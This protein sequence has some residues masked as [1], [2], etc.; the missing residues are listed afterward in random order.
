MMDW[1]RGALVAGM[2]LAG[3]ARADTLHMTVAASPTPLP[4]WLPLYVAA[5]KF[6][7]EEG[8]SVDWVGLRSGSAFAAAVLGG[9]AQIAPL[10]IEAPI[11]AYANGGDLVVICN[12]FDVQPYSVVLSNDAIKRTGILP[13]MPVGDVLQRLKG[14]RIAITG[15]GSATDEFIRHALQFRNIDPDSF[16][17]LQPIG[18]DN[19]MLAAL[20]RKIVD[21]FVMS[22]PADELATQR[23][24]G[25]AVVDPFSG[26]LPEVMDVP[27]SGIVTSRQQLKQQPALFAAVVRA[28]TRS[29]NLL[30]QHPQEAR[31]LLRP[32]FKQ[33]DD[34]T[35]DSV[36][37]RYFAGAARSPMVTKAEYDAV[38]RWANIAAQTP[39]DAPYEAVID[40][41]LAERAVADVK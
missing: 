10:S 21:G 6:F 18:D 12:L 13:A 4:H 19:A 14:L 25:H 11:L 40:N 9:S 16:L 28:M 39:I 2:F 22:S 7:A 30:Q 24:L 3:S 35:F 36:M 33:M 15:P 20:Q 29:L 37:K 26:A 31:A 34:P 41:S 1:L 5:A 23:G 38:L 8:I 27:F 32:Y 17:R